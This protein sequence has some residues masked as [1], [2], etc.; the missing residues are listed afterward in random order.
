MTTEMAEV[1]KVADREVRLALAPGD[2]KLIVR[3]GETA[4]ECRQRVRPS[5]EVTFD[6]SDCTRIELEDTTSKGYH[7]TRPWSVELGMGW[8]NGRDD[9]FVGRLR[10]F[11]FEGS[12]SE[13]AIHIDFSAYRH[14]SR[15]VWAGLSVVSLNE[16]EFIRDGD[17][18]QQRYD[19]STTAFLAALRYEHAVLESA[20]EESSLIPYIEVAGGLSRATTLLVAGREDE[21]VDYGFA[22]SA[23][24]GVQL[25]I[26][27]GFGLFAK[28]RYAVAPTVDNLLGETHDSGGTYV[29]FGVRGTIVG[30]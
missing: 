13:S 24:A 6:A 2:Y 26:V 8:A 27:P 16:A 29:S 22:V 11:G 17:T 25:M 5:S 19:W 7:V 9:A 14:V 15:H 23:A 21:K 3:I 12:A 20:S 4:Q 28:G 1:S 30:R 10:D 18:E